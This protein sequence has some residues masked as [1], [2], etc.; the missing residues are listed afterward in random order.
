MNEL[1]TIEVMPA[2]VA[3]DHER[4]AKLQEKA[5]LQ[6]AIT[7]WQPEPGDN[8]TGIIIGARKEVGAFGYEQDQVLIQQ[9]DNRVVAVWLNGW[10][11]RELQRQG[12]EI[13]SLISLTLVERAQSAAG[14]RY[15]RMS[16][17]IG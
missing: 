4:L 6:A 2:A 17:V 14:R 15:N 16:L 5:K 1:Q 7:T 11:M 8:T 13:G 12:A 10:L 9:P 3:I